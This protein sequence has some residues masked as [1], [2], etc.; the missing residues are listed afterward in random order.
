MQL[1]IQVIVY[2]VIPF[3][4]S[5]L[6]SFY[7]KD[8]K[9]LRTAWRLLVQWLLYLI[10]I[11]FATI[12]LLTI[13][14]SF[15]QLKGWDLK[16]PVP[17]SD[18]I[19]DFLINLNG[20]IF[21]TINSIF[22]LLIL[23]VTFWLAARWLDKRRFIDYGFHFTNRWWRDLG[24]GMFLGV[25][26]MSLI[27]FAEWAAGW[28]VVQPFTLLPEPFGISWVILLSYL[29]AFTAVGITEE[30]LFRGYQLRNL[31]EGLNNR[32]WGPQGALLAAYLIT[33][34]T[35]SSAHLFNPH[36]SWIS[37]LNLILAGLFLGLGYVLTGELAIPIGLHITWNFF[38]GPVFGFPV[39]GISISE[40][41]IKIH[42]GGPSLWTGATFGPEAGLVGIL[43]MILGGLLT[44]LFLRLTRGSIQLQ[45]ILAVYQTGDESS[46]SNQES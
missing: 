4:E 40:S 33:S 22:T 1:S 29:L 36:A 42:Q 38:Q 41:L 28:V 35:F 17:G 39:S 5:P 32:W 26:L 23:L 34:F 30:M 45:S 7:N 14:T 11:T 16:D 37:T 25:F 43:A 6:N 2:K 18:A 31:A 13:Q 44:V 27:F 9:R 19:T 12:A 15:L 21:F 20:G 46:T 3:P 8:Q 10:P 24:F